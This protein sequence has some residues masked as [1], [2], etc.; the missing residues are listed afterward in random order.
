MLTIENNIPVPTTRTTRGG[1]KW[2]IMLQR[3][4][5]KQSVLATSKQAMSIYSAA[6]S[7]NVKIITRR[8]GEDEVRIWKIK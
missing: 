5:P 3:M 8:V 1:G 7:I 2:Q 6:K 4:K